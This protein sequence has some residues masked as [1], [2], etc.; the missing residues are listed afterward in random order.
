M[1]RLHQITG[2]FPEAPVTAL[3][4]LA[5]WTVVNGMDLKKKT[6]CTLAS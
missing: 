3:S 5:K 1:Q 2:P 4:Q 6:D